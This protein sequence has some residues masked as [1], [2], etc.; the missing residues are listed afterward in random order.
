MTKL[1]LQ[2]SSLREYLQTP[3]D[4]LETFK[5]VRAIGYETI[6]IQWINPEIPS[7]VIHD[8][9]EET[10]LNCIGTQ[11]SYD[12]V[13]DNL[14]KFIASNDLWGGIYIT[15]SGIPERFH[16]YDGCLKYAEE[17]NKLSESLETKGKILNFHP[18]AQDIFYYGDKNS[19]EIIFENTRKELQFLLDIYHIIDAGLNP[20]EWI[21]KVEGRNDLIHFK[22]GL[23][24]DADKT[25][26]KPVGHGDINW[27][28]I[29]ATTIET[30][31]KY[32]FAEQETFDKEPFECLQE[33][34]DYLVSNGVK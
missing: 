12:T 20:V 19:L 30:G 8:A 27:E 1:G 3:E 32:A 23:K 13:V 10:N 7:D 11:E 17:L 33:S 14:D 21:Q 31:V 25:V 16:S 24:D 34:Y 28:P 18:R 15:V 5:K 2:I 9:L 4:V 29:I 6:Q 26:L 22:D